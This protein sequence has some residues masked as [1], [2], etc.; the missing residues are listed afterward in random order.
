MA[1]SQIEKMLQ[2]NFQLILVLLDMLMNILKIEENTPS[3]KASFSRWHPK[4]W[5]A[6]LKMAIYLNRKRLFE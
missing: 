3:G 4:W 6:K 1:I 5:P 2:R